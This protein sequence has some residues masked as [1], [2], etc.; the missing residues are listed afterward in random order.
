MYPDTDSGEETPVI[1]T[2]IAGAAAAAAIKVTGI[3]EGQMM[4]ASSD[5]Y[6][7]EEDSS[8]DD[9]QEEDNDT[10]YD[11]DGNRRVPLLSDWPALPSPAASRRMAIERGVQKFHRSQAELQKSI[12][13]VKRTQAMTAASAA[14][15]GEHTT[16]RAKTI[17]SMG[18]ALDAVAIHPVRL[19]PRRT[20]SKQRQELMEVTCD[21][22]TRILD[23]CT[24]IMKSIEKEMRD[25]I[26][27]AMTD[28]RDNFGP[29]LVPFG[30]KTIATEFS[31]TRMDEVCMRFSLPKKR[32]YLKSQGLLIPPRDFIMKKAV[33]D[34]W[35][36][37]EDR[38]VPDGLEIAC[39]S[40]ME[41]GMAEMYLTYPLAAKRAYLE[42]EGVL[43]GPRTVQKPL[44]QYVM[45][46][47]GEDKGRV[48]EWL[49]S[50]DDTS[51]SAKRQR[52]V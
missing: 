48:R 23:Q 34:V 38:L 24:G 18:P 17:A 16:K 9:A 44:D 4:D 8:S 41:P 37:F 39:R 11:K 28:V 21:R 10:K 40:L 47:G 29:E 32:A 30:L 15:D 26:Q 35:F 46:S 33:A 43:A 6:F 19:T 5:E 2:A 1:Y 31:E 25:P 49:A 22:V 14:A 12:A 13:G 20:K 27:L 3:L 50:L 36:N 7:T 42:R 52:T 51:Q 45:P